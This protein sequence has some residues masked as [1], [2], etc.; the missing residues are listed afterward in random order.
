M[1]EA[2]QYYTNR[3]LS[4]LQFN[5]RV[6]DEAGNPRVPLAER[7]TFASIYQTN[8][9]EFFMVRVGT[10]MVRARSKD[11]YKEDK[12]N[13][14]AKKQVKKIL[15]SVR[16]LEQK[17]ARVVEQLWGELEPHGIRIINFNRLSHEE[18]KML[19]HYF[20]VHIAPFLN[21]MIVGSQQPFPFLVNQDL[22]VVVALSPA[23]GKTGKAK[24][25]KKD[26][27]RKL[28][29]V[30]CSNSVFK[31]LIEI[32]TRPGTFMLSE[33][34][35]LHFVGALYNRYK[36]EEKAVMRIT[37]S[38]DIDEEH[39]YYENM[40]YRDMMEALILL[41]DRL[42]PVRLELSRHLSDETR[43]ELADHL[44]MKERHIIEVNTPLDLSFVFQL[45]D[46]L[47]GK[48]ELFYQKRQP[49]RCVD[50]N[51]SESMLDQI[52]R[53]DVLL[54]YPFQSM[55]PFLKLL[56]DA[57]QD[58]SVLSIKMTLYRV[59]D[60][61]K[62]IESLLE[63]AENGKEVVVMIELRARFDEANNIDVS[64]ALEEA[65]CQVFYGIEQY[66]VHSKLCLITRRT[67][68]GFSYI[69]QI[70]TGNYNEKTS[71][72]YTD[73]SLMTA[74]QEIGRDAARVFLAL[75]KGELLE[76]SD[77]L[78][79]A[80]NCLQNRIIE[81]IDE[82]IRRAEDD[83]EAYIGIKI[84]SLTD[85]I[86]IDK[87]IEASQ[88]GV[89]I[90]MIVRGICCLKPGVPE[91]TENIT[92]VS[93]VGRFLE[94]S[95]IYRFGTGDRERMYISSADFMTRN[96]LR[97]VEVATPIL[98]PAVREKI[99]HIFELNLADD[100][101]GKIQTAEGLYVRRSL[102]E[103]PLNSQE[104]LYEEAYRAAGVLIPGGTWRNSLP[105]GTLNIG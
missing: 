24:G 30:P 16:E 15:K 35:I 84:N 59:A 80:P 52:G 73:L 95:R 18:G 2:N 42:G 64:R 66:K 60:Q 34:L 71:T 26:K 20:N 93:I 40:D 104:E 62:I 6:L 12:T 86:L 82:E 90:E 105:K 54:S 103:E 41:R 79:V 47:Y 21:P 43:K 96:T 4:W 53:K 11:D 87:L 36:I 89:R 57:A 28:G 19:E 100:E 56:Q 22:Y 94:H 55:R 13:L 83:E 37:R 97:R 74:N 44:R 70:G 32:P 98:D 29:I 25:G 58:E 49:Q 31:R 68:D 51:Y 7:L 45:R 92:V 14:S 88:A 38:A 67:E 72:L 48:T 17:R 75:Q 10:L 69:T 78:L 8:L 81:F 63:A 46:V 3:E 27:E 102:H 33:E 85:R 76:E 77:V 5:E 23:G 39:F 50:V 61:S 9:D 101:K 99:R 1:K 91:Y 65:G